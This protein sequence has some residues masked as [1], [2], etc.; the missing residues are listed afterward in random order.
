MAMVPIVETKKGRKTEIENWY[1]TE[2]AAFKKL[3]KEAVDRYDTAPQCEYGY[4]EKYGKCP[5]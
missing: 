3:Q 2:I 5:I 1:S 4:Q